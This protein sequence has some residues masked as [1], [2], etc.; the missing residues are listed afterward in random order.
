[1][2]LTIASKIS[3]FSAALIAVTAASIISA[4][5]LG[6]TRS[7]LTN[8]LKQYSTLALQEG[9]RLNSVLNDSVSD[10]QFIAQLQSVA[11]YAERLNSAVAD[12][13]ES[14][15]KL[16]NAVQ[17]E[18]LNLLQ[19]S[20]DYH[21]LR[22]IDATGQERIRVDRKNNRL[23]PVKQLALQDKSSSTYVTDTLAL[24]PGAVYFSEINL[25]REHGQVVK[26]HIPTLRIAIAI[27]TAQ[28]PVGMLI[29]NINV[30]PQLRYLRHALGDLSEYAYIT[31][32][33]GSYLSHHDSSMTFGFDTSHQH[34][35][36][37]RLPE[38]DAFYSNTKQLSVVL[39]PSQNSAELAVA[40]RKIHY[41]ASNPERFIAVGIAAPRE[42]I[43]ADEIALIRRNVF[44]AVILTITGM[45]SALVLSLRVTRPLSMIAS[46]ADAFTQQR[47]PFT[48]PPPGNDEIAQLGRTIKALTD[49]VLDNEQ[50]LSSLNATLEQRVEE[51]SR[52]L[53]ASQ[54]ML[55]TVLDALPN[56]LFWKDVDGKYLG[57]NQNFAEDAGLQTPAEIIGKTDHQ[58]PWKVHAASYQEDDRAVINNMQPKLNIIEP[59]TLS[60]G[61]TRWLETNKLP[62]FDT[63]NRV[64]GMLGSYRDITDRRNA[65]ISLRNSEERLRNSQH[66]AHVGTWDWNIQDN[67]LHWSDEFYSIFGLQPQ[68]LT[69]SY[70]AFL[71]SIHPEDI[72]LVTSS[73]KHSLKHQERQYYVHHR[74]VR[75]DGE[76]RYV[77]EHGE[78]YRSP[79]GQPSR[80][81]G[82]V[83][84]ITENILVQLALH[85]EKERA[86]RYLQVSEAMIVALDI[87]GNITRINQRSCELL[88]Y[89]MDKLQ[90]RNWFDTVIPADKREPVKSAFTALMS[91]RQRRDNEHSSSYYENELLCSNGEIITISWHNTV[92]Y[93]HNGNATGTLSS[94]HDM[95]QRKRMEKLKDEFISTVS[96]ELRTPL[97]SIRG[98]LR[99]IL[100]NVLGEI[101]PKA[102]ELLQVA[103]NNSERLLLLINDLLDLQKIEAGMMSFNFVPLSPTTLLKEAVDINRPYANE[104]HIQLQLNTNNYAG[105]E[106]FYGDHDRLIQVMNNLIS[107]AIKF[108]PT[109]ARVDVILDGDNEEVR[110]QVNDIGPGVPGQ[111]SAHLFDKFTQ[112]DSSN[113]RQKGGTGLGLNIAKLIVDKHHGA[114]GYHDNPGGGSSFRVTLPI[115]TPA[116]GET[117]DG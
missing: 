82:A 26:P 92:E 78:V 104:H 80:M 97:T 29:I 27:T 10:L 93:D 115:S 90:G 107:N 55:E 38:L 17:Q 95:T 117:H 49:E 15:T 70:E 5:Y 73:I 58:M 3:L 105:D 79:E 9:L 101:P 46:A 69:P 31:N 45:F 64:T 50:R 42:L 81:I 52:E 112:V 67:T 71:A 44:W 65:E 96:H 91:Q 22:F 14:L 40:F 83:H 106:E 16:G 89:R 76:V 108:S 25:N 110:I 30:G 72:E 84:D 32:A 47:I 12:E 57:C 100:G 54:K 75:P 114:I 28:Q 4:F 6:G 63:S 113:T 48:A 41:D 37:D 7:L 88:G 111:F 99:L 13:D 94:G 2:R 56:R 33:N 34:R 21:Q 53:T 1:M 24:P 19:H 74:I 60:D 43:L 116:T 85:R 61:S 102:L 11:A 86:E 68:T 8:S 109:G 36:Q 23:L 35:V 51:R 98:A 39:L 18:F 59:I 66:I 87:H 77:E 20:N 62:L 103:D